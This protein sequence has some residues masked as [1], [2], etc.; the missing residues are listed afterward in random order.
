MIWILHGP[1]PSFDLGCH[2]EQGDVE[3]NCNFQNKKT[4]FNV[5]LKRV[6]IE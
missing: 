4:L 2:K 5:E 3:K 1:K 6:F